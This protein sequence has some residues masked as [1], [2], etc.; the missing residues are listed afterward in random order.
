[1]ALDQIG[2]EELQDGD[3]K[4][5]EMT[6]FDHLEELRWHIIRAVI[7][8]LVFGVAAFI[9]D[10]FVFNTVIFGPK[11]SDFI[12]Y[13]L[14][15]DFSHWANIGEILCIAPPDF[16]F[17]TPNFGEPFLVHIQVSFVIGFV[18][19][20]PFLFW[21]IWKFIKPGLYEKERRLTR[22]AV[23]ICSFL[24]LFGVLFGYYVVSPFAISFL[25]GY[26]L[27]GV[28]PLPSLSSYISYLVMLTL[29]VGLVFELPVATHV[30]T[31]LGIISSQFM[32][33]YRRHA[34]VIIIV[35]GAVI[36]PPDVFSQLLVSI[37]LVGLYEVSI[38]V[39]KRVEKQ[40][41]IEEK[42]VTPT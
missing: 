27:P 19:A 28:T 15:C 18:L 16:Q 23:G 4:E 26:Q 21:E 22:H 14:L 5:K 41:A 2:T 31:K 37:P 40:Q 11:H 24:F 17:V 10:D 30:L 20:I 35:V 7:A 36:T 8:V 6:F 13:R 32:K 34:I 9:F 38:L 33:N 25:A 39:A 42:S 3:K 12:T 29:P 1:M